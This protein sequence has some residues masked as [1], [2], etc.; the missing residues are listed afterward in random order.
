MHVWEKTQFRPQVELVKLKPL[1]STYKELREGMGVKWVNGRYSDSQKHDT[2]IFM[3]H[4]ATSLGVY[5]QVFALFF[6]GKIDHKS[7]GI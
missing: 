5:S 4:G 3:S 2:F 1:I 6:Q 7:I